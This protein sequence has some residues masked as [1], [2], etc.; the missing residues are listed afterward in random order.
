MKFLLFIFITLSFNTIAF[1]QDVVENNSA[2]DV[3]KVTVYEQDFDK[4]KADGDPKI[5]TVTIY[6]KK[7]NIIEEIDYK[8]GKVNESIAVE[9]DALG[10][11]IKETVKNDKGN[12]I[13]I[14]DIKYKD[15]L[16]VEKV[17]YDENN[18]IKSRK[19]YQ[20]EKF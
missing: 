10:N 16:R 4:G 8:A 13:K 18:V 20:Y 6:D 1:C 9:Y 3:K 11:K 12:I 5:K 17:T 2:K 15:G 7:G 19:T 14:T